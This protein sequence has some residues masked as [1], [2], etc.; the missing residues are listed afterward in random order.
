MAKLT[1]GQTDKRPNLQMTN[2]QMYR[3]TVKKNNNNQILAICHF[4]KKASQMKT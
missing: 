2:G 3:V 4:M 1:N